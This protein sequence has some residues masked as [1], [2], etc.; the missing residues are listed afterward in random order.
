[1]TGGST[2]PTTV[3]SSSEAT[4]HPASNTRLSCRPRSR[5]T[6]AAATAASAA[7]P[8]SPYS[9][10]SPAPPKRALTE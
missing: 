2:A 5:P 3:V 8:S 4:G 9:R 7:P 6:N 10:G 1:M